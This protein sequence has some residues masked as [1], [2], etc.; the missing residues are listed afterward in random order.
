[1]GDFLKKN[2]ARLIITFALLCDIVG[3]ALIWKYGLPERIMSW[4]GVQAEIMGS[5][6]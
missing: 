4:L 3:V 5:I 6:L 2:A 1:M